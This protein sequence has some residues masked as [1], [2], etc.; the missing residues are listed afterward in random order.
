M[1]LPGAN[2]GGGLWWQAPRNDFGGRFHAD[3]VGTLHIKEERFYGGFMDFSA[4]VATLARLTIH[5]TRTDEG[6]KFQG[7]LQELLNE[8][9]IS[10]EHSTPDPP[11]TRRS[12][13]A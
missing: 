3:G 2:E 8:L 1:D 7:Q 5:I 10:H 12:T 13:T 6:G 9:A 11:P 4:D